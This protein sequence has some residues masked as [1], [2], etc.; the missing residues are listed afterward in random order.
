MRGKHTSPGMTLA[1]IIL[2][3]PLLGGGCSLGFRNMHPGE[4]SAIYSP[5]FTDIITRFDSPEWLWTRGTISGDFSLSD[6]FREEA[7]IATI[8]TGDTRSPDPID[9][10]YLAICKIDPSGA[11]TALARTLLFD[12]NPIPRS[13][14]VDN[15]AYLPEARPMRNVRAQ[16]IQDKFG[17]G[18]YIVVYFWD[19]SRPANVWFCGYKLEGGNLVRILDISLCQTNPGVAKANLDTGFTSKASGGFQLVFPSAALPDEIVAKMGE[20]FEPPLWGNVFAMDDKGHYRQADERYGK[21]YARIENSWN[22]AYLQALMVD[23][24]DAADLAW[25]EYHL[26]L[27]YYFIGREAMA[28]TFLG[29]AKSNAD[30][31]RLSAAVAEALNLLGGASGR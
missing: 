2:C 19:D 18:E 24:L 28:A 30:D 8:Q 29:K 12:A 4:E 31:A 26:G 16:V 13:R 9:A 6:E 23:R 1:A 10:A 15:N 27:L 17:L 5:L 20:G 3:A 11:R 21:N 14:S 25:F 7:V 22:Q